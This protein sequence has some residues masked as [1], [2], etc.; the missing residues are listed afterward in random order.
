MAAKLV[1]KARKY[2]RSTKIAT[3]AA[4]SSPNRIQSPPIGL[5]G[6]SRT[7]TSLLIRPHQHQHRSEVWIALIVCT[8]GSIHQEKDI[9]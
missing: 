8:G 6:H 3:L 2:D 7:R 5:Q 4:N 1:T 9:H